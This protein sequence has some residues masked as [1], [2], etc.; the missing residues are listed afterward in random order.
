MKNILNT[1]VICPDFPCKTSL[2]KKATMG[3]DSRQKSLKNTASCLSALGLTLLLAACGGGGGSGDANPMPST[4]VPKAQA[5]MP[6]I[7]VVSA[8]PSYAADSAELAAWNYLQQSRVQ[9]GFGALVQN[10]RLDA[11]A[12]AHARYLT[13]SSVA[14]SVSVTGHEEV[15]GLSETFTGAMPWDRAQHQGYGTEVAE[16]LASETWSYSVESLPVLPTL[17]QRGVKSMQHLINTVYHLSAAMYQGGEVGF[18]ASLQSVDRAGIRRDEYRF[19]SL[20]GFRKTDATVQLGTGSLATFPCEGS[21]GVATAFIPAEER[22]NP[23]P[24]LNLVSQKVGPPIYLK[25]DTGQTLVLQT[26][27]VSKAGVAVGTRVLTKA[28]DPAQKIG[29]HEVFVIPTVA[30]DAHSIYQ[31]NLTGTVDGKPFSRMFNMTTGS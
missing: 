20:N 26:S 15:K 25:V 24:E 23:M 6:R 12:L 21:T 5:V 13:S 7:P 22:P 27:S 19:G 31:V 4:A 2:G 3:L 18:A 29:S 1:T 14:G 8:A 16:I 28:N 9:C 11:A 10:P 30:L 17:A